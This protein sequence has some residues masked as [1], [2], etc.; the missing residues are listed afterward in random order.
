MH[1]LRRLRARILT[2][3]SSATRA[4]V[5]G[6]HVKDQATRDLLE[7]V[8]A[9]FL[10]GYR[11]AA[12]APVPEAAE[13]RLEDVPTRFRG[14]AYEGAAMA[15]GVRDAL[16]VTGRRHLV[17][18][19]GGRGELHLYM[20]YVGIG[21][22]MAR[23]P[24]LR[25][26][27]LAMPD[28]LLRWLAL[29]GYGFHQAYFHTRKYVRDQ[30]RETGFRWPAGGPV[31]YRARVIDQ[32]IGRALW[33]VGGADADRVTA[34][35]GGYAPDRRADLYS[36]AGLAATYAGG[37]GEAEL[38]R[39]WADAGQY[40]P[41]VAQG[42]AFAA[43]ARVRAGLVCPHN[44]VATQVLCGLSS[45]DAA[46]VTDA[47]LPQAAATGSRPGY[48]NWRLAIAEEFRSRW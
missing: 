1:T 18:F 24:R 25:W 33:F 38:S 48:E 20:A 26:G 23:V 17:S 6:F 35:I 14:F 12:E 22:A 40:R 19:M 32:G 36:G 34:L 8:G 11:Y 45:R 42:S 13:H 41:N 7:M 43:G 29:D 9:T 2:P 10:R 28:P 44:E 16:G 39:F 30:Y 37:A 4:D 5:R 31:D 46:K 21:W 3:D 15:F 27:R 47:A